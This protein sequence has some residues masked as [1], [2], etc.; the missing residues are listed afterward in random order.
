MRKIISTASL[1][2]LCSILYAQSSDITRIKSHLQ[3]LTKTNG[4]RTYR[5]IEQLNTS[6]DFIN[7]TF[8]TYS[9]SVSFQ[10]YKVRNITYKNVICSFGT[11]HKKRIIIGAHYDVC[12]NQEGADDNASGVV[13]LLELARLLK[14]QNLKYRIDLVAYSLEEPPFFR[15]VNMGS[16]IHAQYLKQ[17]E[18][19]V[20]GM[21]SVEMIGFFSDEMKSQSYPI[22]LLSLIYGNRG[23][24]ITLVKR[25]GSGK[26]TKRFCRKFKS[27]RTIRTKKFTGPER[28]QG[29]DF[30]DHMNYWNQDFSAFMITDTSFYRNSNYHKPSDKMETLDI[31]RMAKVID[32]IYLALLKY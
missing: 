13:A 26:F 30:S 27:S 16:F 9:D 11:H 8:R 19:E 14:D 20:I 5:D 24:Y 10:E 17:S 4:F 6:A 2:L 7:K 1:I 23:N 31:D 21:I 18:A 12:G 28:L 22:K 32:G 25:F 29:M 3:E 15:T